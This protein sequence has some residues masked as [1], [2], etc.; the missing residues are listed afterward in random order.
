MENKSKK[1]LTILTAVIVVVFLG[2]LTLAVRQGLYISP[3]ETA[4]AFFSE[5]FSKTGQLSY[6][7]PLNFELGNIL[8]PRSMAS[9]DGLLVPGS[10]IGLPILYGSL[11]TIFSLG[12]IPFITPII[13]ALAVLAWFGFSRRLMSDKLALFSSILLAI[14]PAWWYYSARSMMHNV[15]FTSLLIFSAY[16][17]LV[18]PWH[19]KVTWLNPA[20]TGLFIGLAIFVRTSEIIW[21]ALA[22]LLIGFLARQYLSKRKLLIMAI[23]LLIGLAPIP[24][25]N[26]AT[27]GSSISTG[28]TIENGVEEV[29]FDGASPA[30]LQIDQ[31]APQIWSR[32]QEIVKPIFPFGL[33]PRNILRHISWY[34]LG[35][36]WWM[37]VLAIIGV[38]LFYHDKEKGADK[39][40]IFFWTFA[41]V[42]IWLGLMY[43][44]WVIHDNPDPSKVTIGTSYLRYWLPVFVMMTPFAAY[45]IDWLSHRART[46]L[47]RKLVVL[48]LL[49]LPFGLSIHAVYFASND[50]LLTIRENLNQS[51][52]IKEKILDLTP[53]DSIIITDRADKIFFPERSIRQP[54]RSELTYQSMP[55]MLE[56]AELYYYGI[57]FPQSDLDYLNE[58]KLYDLGLKIKWIETFKAESLYEI[59]PQ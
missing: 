32:V 37:S 29:V 35:L 42:S 40:K 58:T 30:V 56:K 2:S 49:L 10:F 39:R 3:D 45:A 34:G 20:L 14:H 50:S 15:L 13:A 24:I 26:A 44:S 1:Y 8:V 31:N 46:G 28:Y 52:T 53:Q 11:G 48:I 12:F 38:A 55:A 4:N 5:Q 22:I 43:G 21:L 51:L 19:K 25:F 36:F 33:H 59:L 57:T 17:I 47:A 16:F 9:M 27:Y 23:G 54:L 7:D 6:F 41:L 18:R